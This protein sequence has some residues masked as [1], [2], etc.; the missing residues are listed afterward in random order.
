[1]LSLLSKWQQSDFILYGFDMYRRSLTE[2]HQK[3]IKMESLWDKTPQLPH[4]HRDSWEKTPQRRI[5][6]QRPP[7]DRRLLPQFTRLPDTH[8]WRRWWTCPG[9]SSPAASP[10][11]W[12]PLKHSTGNGADWAQRHGDGEVDAART[13]RRVTHLWCRRSR[14][15]AAS[16]A[17]PCSSAVA[18]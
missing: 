17:G 14:A 3:R 18:F 16:P 2:S 6:R 8:T 5:W 4:L 13:T 12:W 7:A 10:P 1:M 15:R 11:A 9:S